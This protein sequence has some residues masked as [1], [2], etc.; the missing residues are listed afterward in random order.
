MSSVGTAARITA[1]PTRRLV[2][3]RLSARPLIAVSASTNRSKGAR[4][5]GEWWPP[6]G[7]YVCQYAADWIAVKARWELNLDAAERRSL[8]KQ[9]TR[10]SG[11]QFE[12]QSPRE[13][14]V[15]TAEP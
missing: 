11:E 13:A 9:L 3:G 2:D 7:S 6:S 4:D 5:P 8:E 12:F 1:G 10:C 15:V 14:P